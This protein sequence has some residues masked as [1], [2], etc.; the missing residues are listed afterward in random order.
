LLINKDSVRSDDEEKKTIE[1]IVLQFKAG[2]RAAVIPVLQ[3]I[4]DKLGYLS[5][6]ATEKTANITGVSINTVYGVATF[7][8]QFLFVKPARH[9]IRVC[10][11][12]ACYV[13]GTST[14]LQAI[15]RTLGI[16]EGETTPDGEYSL[17][18][19]ACI[20]ACAFA[21]TIR[22]DED[23]YGQLTPKKIEELFSR[24]SKQEEAHEGNAGE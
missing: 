10:R 8:S 6:Y 22:I 12:T 2:N 21:P 5:P 9:Q 24:R 11:G 4:Q 1:E 18:T 13:R 7:Y 23:T 3:A 16:K 19:V 17:E 14:I 20:G 15:E